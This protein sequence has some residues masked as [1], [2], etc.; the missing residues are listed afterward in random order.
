MQTGDLMSM[1]VSDDFLHLGH[2]FK[3]RREERNLSLKEIENATS[4][5]SHFLTAIEEGQVEKLISPVYAQGFIKK[6]ASFLELDSDK[7]LQEYPEVRKLLHSKTIEKEEFAFGLG[8]LELRD[9]PNHEERK[10]PNFLW[11]GL[12]ILIIAS[13]WF[14]IRY[15][16][17]F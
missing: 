2:I 10:W 7:I 17:N 5:R 11:I 6:Y 13:I 12:S 16:A 3:Q 1:G 9:H 14:L 15:I 4:I 8:T